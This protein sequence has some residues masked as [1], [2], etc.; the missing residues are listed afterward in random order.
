MCRWLVLTLALGALASCRD[1][2]PPSAQ[3]QAPSAAP[4]SSA[5]A[6]PSAR[7]SV[8]KVRL[9]ASHP[10]GVPLHPARG[11]DGVSGRLPDGAE[12]E[13]LAKSPDGR[14]LEVRAKDGQSG[15]ITKRYVASPDASRSEPAGSLGSDSPFASRQACEKALGAGARLPRG[16]KLARVGTWNVRWFPDGKP[17]KGS[18]GQGTDL[19][20]L[21]CVIAWADVDALAVQEFKT[22]ARAKAA[23]AELRRRLD[24]HT[25]GSWDARFDDCPSADAQHVGVLFDSRRVKAKAA[26][27]LAELNPHGEACKNSLR[28]GLSLHLSFPGGLDFHLVSAHTK[29]GTER[30]SFDLREKTLTKLTDAHRALLAAEPDPDVLFAGDFNTMGCKDCSPPVTADEELALTDRKLAGLSISH[31]RLPAEKPCSEY[32]QGRGTLLDHFIAV[33]K[34]AEVGPDARALVSGLC[35]E[36]AC[37][38]GPSGEGPPA[39]RDLSDHCPLFLDIPDRDLD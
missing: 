28:P 33:G 3:T 14:W 29:S 39:H 25:R 32:H 9:K 34:F 4:T 11:A 21:A 24:Q 13:V 15:W 2:M 35:G 23:L 27:T 7:P 1:R 19:A 31:R 37:A 30:R 36:T 20:W 26:T 10:D 38:V 17:G 18:E 12:V 8:E 5:A 16:E 22:N 6:T